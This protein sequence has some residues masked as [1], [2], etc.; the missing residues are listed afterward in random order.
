MFVLEMSKPAQH[1]CMVSC[2]H[3][4]EKIGVLVDRAT[5]QLCI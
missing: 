4:I 3:A 1:E 5:K 2:F